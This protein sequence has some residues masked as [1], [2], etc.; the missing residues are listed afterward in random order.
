VIWK[1]WSK[2]IYAIIADEGGV[3]SHAAIIARELEKPCIIG[4]EIATQ[5]LEDGEKV[6][7]NAEEGVVN[8][9][10]RND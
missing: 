2:A 6:E 9:L 8:I 4:T 10:R 5:A 3:T 1:R 7:V